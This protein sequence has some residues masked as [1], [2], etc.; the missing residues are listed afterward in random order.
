M[1]KEEGRREKKIIMILSHE[2]KR[3]GRYTIDGEKGKRERGRWEGGTGR[4][5]YKDTHPISY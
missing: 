5:R 2:V 1:G 3:E 4:L